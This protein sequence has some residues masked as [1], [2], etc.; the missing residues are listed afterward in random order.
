M[1]L[2]PS[3]T[4]I[5]PPS[6]PAEVHTAEIVT[7]LSQPNLNVNVVF[8]ETFTGTPDSFEFDLR[9]QLTNAENE[10]STSPALTQW[11]DFKYAITRDYDFAQEKSEAVSNYFDSM[12]DLIDE[13]NDP[14]DRRIDHPV[15]GVIEDWSSMG[16]LMQMN[17]I[18]QMINTTYNITEGLPEMGLKIERKLSAGM[19]GG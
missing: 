9:I 12:M 2:I 7:E 11:I 3:N 13:I 4:S 5:T 19:S 14:T 15:W 10:G 17:V 18:M 8:D 16:G 1:A 6:S